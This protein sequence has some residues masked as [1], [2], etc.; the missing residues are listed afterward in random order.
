MFVTVNFVLQKKLKIMKNAVLSFTGLL[1][2]GLL[3]TQAFAQKT[4]NAKVKIRVEK[5]E[6]GKMEVTEKEFDTDGMS[7]EEIE[8]SIEKTQ[9]SL[10]GDLGVN[11]KI[12][13][14]IDDERNISENDEHF[15]WHGDA[16]GGA[17]PE[18][19]VYKKKMGKGGQEEMEEF[20]W[21]MDDFADKMKYL[22]EEIPRRIER[23]LPKIYTWNDDS[24]TPNDSKSVK[25][26]DVYPNS[27]EREVINVRFFAP[28][29]G[30][31]KISVID[32]NGNVV[33]KE[34]AKDFKGEYVGQ[35][36]LKK[37]SKG[38]YFVIVSQGEDGISKRVKI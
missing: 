6:N 21:N 33:A 24:W 27:P 26:L 35:I 3:G 10:I 23:H 17:H 7:P 1:L 37:G 34:E 9:D 36:K 4:P 2:V 15:E 19:H 8:M 16:R 30:D 31:V 29:M 18:V 38:T 32:L 12:K 11:K 28:E 22:G 13:V 20:E 14:I 25:M 5:T